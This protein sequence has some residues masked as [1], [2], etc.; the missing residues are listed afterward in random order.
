ME[1][2]KT[3]RLTFCRGLQGRLLW[4]LLGFIVLSAQAQ[5]IIPPNPDP[6]PPQ[7]QY[8]PPPSAASSPFILPPSANPGMMQGQ[9]AQQ[10]PLSEILGEAGLAPAKG[11]TRLP[12]LWPYYLAAAIIALLIFSILLIWIIRR[13][14]RPKPVPVIPADVRA[15]N[16]LEAL[17]P[18]IREAKAREFSYQASEIIRGYIEDR[19][20]MR[21]RNRTTREFLNQSMA[22]DGGISE[23][24]KGALLQ[25]LNYCDLA[26]FARQMLPPDQLNEMF[27]S[28]SQFIKETRPSIM[29]ISGESNTSPTHE[30]KEAQSS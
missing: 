1:I 2:F 9:G 22:T 7:K 24:H 28:A 23:K 3:Y 11:I 17:R 30:Q 26:K 12:P 18:L 27:T 8:S 14:R 29:A 13:N 20:D 16:G 15:L 5:I 25:F 6:T 4:T 19:F 21:A 10:P